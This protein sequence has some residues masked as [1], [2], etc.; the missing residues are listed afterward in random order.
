MIYRT[1]LFGSVESFVCALVTAGLFVHFSGANFDNVLAV[2]MAIASV[3]FVYLGIS[4][5][6]DKNED[7]R[8]ELRVER[9]FTAQ[10]DTKRELNDRIAGL[11]REF[12]NLANKN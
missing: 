3:G 7:L 5:Y 1:R 4:S 2:V 12:N 10:E 6:K 9:E 11:E 8:S